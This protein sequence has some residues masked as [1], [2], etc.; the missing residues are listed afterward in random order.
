M[1]KLILSVILATVTL[2]ACASTVTR[3]FNDLGV[4]S[5]IQVG[6]TFKATLVQGSDYSAKVTID[7][8]YEPYLDVT[9][10]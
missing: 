5:S 4:F 7:T 10:S 8:A 9:P 3:N 2:S 1:K 6:N